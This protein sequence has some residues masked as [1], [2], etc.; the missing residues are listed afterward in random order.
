[1]L[2]NVTSIRVTVRK[3]LRR[4]AGEVKGIGIR[5]EQMAEAPS[6]LLSIQPYI[7]AG[8][9]ATRKPPDTQLC[10]AATL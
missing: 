10:K 5:K 3:H 7:L 8:S 6:P 9:P 2:E 1:M 4:D